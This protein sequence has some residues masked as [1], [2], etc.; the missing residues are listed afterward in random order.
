MLNIYNYLIDIFGHLFL[1]YLLYIYIYIYI[2][3]TN[4]MH[5]GNIDGRKLG[6]LIHQIK[7]LWV[8]KIRDVELSWTSAKIITSFSEFV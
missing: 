8:K 7:I 4:I 6:I 3:M 5:C 1:N 2:Y